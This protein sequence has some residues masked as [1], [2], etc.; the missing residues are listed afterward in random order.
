MTEEKAIAFWEKY[1]NNFSPVVI[2]HTK[3]NLLFLDPKPLFNCTPEERHIISASISEDVVKKLGEPLEKVFLLSEAWQSIPD[4]DS[5]EFIMPSK[6]PKRQEILLI[7]SKD[8]NQ[9]MQA[10]VIPIYK[11]GTER[12]LDLENKMYLKEGLTH[13]LDA[14]FAGSSAA[15]N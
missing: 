15:I 4:K 6:D 13:I 10:I 7:H 11:K 5:K 14:F 1:K 3:H 12:M 9:K 8:K 2:L